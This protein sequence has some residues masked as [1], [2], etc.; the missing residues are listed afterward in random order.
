MTRE[1]YNKLLEN[2]NVIGI[3]MP[4]EF[5]LDWA[6]KIADAL[7][8][9]IDNSFDLKWGTF[10]EKRDSYDQ[11]IEP[12]MPN[13]YREYHIY[14]GIDKLAEVCG[15]KLLKVTNDSDRYPVKKYF[16]HK[17]IKF[18]ELCQNDDDTKYN[19]PERSA[20]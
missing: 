9:V 5:I 17:G 2:E 4:N 16:Y 8:T 12:C 1:E 6:D 18:F 3:K 13:S 14:R 7:N 20:S 19:V 11:H 10:D 15:E